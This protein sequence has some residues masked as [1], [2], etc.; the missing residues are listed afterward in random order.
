MA[1]TA[2]AEE[3]N[4]S[5]PFFIFKSGS[6]YFAVKN[7]PKKFTSSWLFASASSVNSAAP[8]IP[9][10]ALQMQR[11]MPSFSS[12][13]F[14]KA[15]FTVCSSVTSAVMCVTPSNELPRRESSYTR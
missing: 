8:E 1:K 2:A 13:I 6:A 11:S 5:L 10:P 12:E 4:I 9:K 3:T 15:D 14:S 7:A